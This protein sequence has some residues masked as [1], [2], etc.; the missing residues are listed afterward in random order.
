M[1]ITSTSRRLRSITILAAA[2][3]LA[4]VGCTS[5]DGPSPFDP[6][7]MDDAGTATDTEVGATQGALKDRGSDTASDDAPLPGDPAR[8]E[9]IAAMHGLLLDAA[10]AD[11]KALRAATDETRLLASVAPVVDAFCAQSALRDCDVRASDVAS[12]SLAAVSRTL[13]V[14]DRDAYLRAVGAVLDR[15][16][17]TTPF[18]DAQ[19]ASLDGIFAALPATIDDVPAADR[20]IA[21]IEANA[22]RRMSADEADI[23]LIASAVARHSMGYWSREATATGSPWLGDDPPVPAA[24]IRWGNVIGADVLGA[25]W[26]GVG[27]AVF[28]GVGAAPGAGIGAG[29][30]S[31]GALLSEIF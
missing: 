9:A 15:A 1:S 18:T 24:R 8:Y 10:A 5:G 27:G 28:G 11:M 31:A 20:E 7:F 29:I 17:R 3:A 19:R 6:G 21:A 14:E 12:G 2:L 23:V 4:A 16:A 13:N 30:C 26:G 22:Q 25:I